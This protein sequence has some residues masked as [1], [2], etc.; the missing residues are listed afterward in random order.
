MNILVVDSDTESRA[1]LASRITDACR[2]RFSPNDFVLGLSGPEDL[3]ARARD[4]DLLVLGS[5]V[6]SQVRQITAI[7]RGASEHVQIVLFVPPSEYNTQVFSVANDTGIR[8][9]FPLD[10][11]LSALSREL[12]DVRRSLVSLGR[13]RLGKLTVVKSVKGGAGATS[14]VAALGE[15]SGLAEQRT[16]LWDFDI[17]GRDLSRALGASQEFGCFANGWLTSVDSIDRDS[18]QSACFPVTS[19]VSLL[20]PPSKI[21]SAFELAVRPEGIDVVEKV[22]E[23]AESLF[24]RVIVDAGSITGPAMGMLM[25]MADEVVFVVGDCALG[26]TALDSS[27]RYCA[28]MLEGKSK[29]F[30]IATHEQYSLSRLQREVDPEVVFGQDAWSLPTFAR[31]ENTLN[32]AGTGSTLY[33]MGSRR[34]RECLERI[35]SKLEFLTV[36]S[37][38]SAIDERIFEKGPIAFGGW[39]ESL[40]RLSGFNPSRRVIPRSEFKNFAVGKREIFSEKPRAEMISPQTSLRIETSVSDPERQS[41]AFHEELKQESDQDIELSRIAPFTPPL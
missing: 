41:E 38:D 7:V 37:E 2:E 1:Q 14:L 23:V 18:L 19:H 15:L 32:W 5:G 29:V 39:L 4:C 3:R 31:E 9:V 24:D 40:K 20:T 11:S 8:K 6:A 30:F 21:A 35:A 22:V 17:E 33:S 25:R 27:I 16:L 36:P 10:A 26:A 34:T 13:I 12:V 28:P